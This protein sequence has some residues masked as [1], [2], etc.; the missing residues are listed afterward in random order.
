VLALASVWIG[1]AALV[2]AATMV[3]YRPAF[4]DW[5]VPMVLYFGSPGAM[6]LAGLVL[7]AYR[8][9]DPT[10][11]G[12]SAQRLQAKIAIAFALIAAAIV[13]LLF[14]FSEKLARIEP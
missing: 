2:L 12:L 6:C 14:I 8:K 10:D 3:L 13:Y 9:E 5:T 7:W 1:L 11:P 4:T